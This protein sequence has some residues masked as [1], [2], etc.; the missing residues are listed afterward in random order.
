MKKRLNINVYCFL[1]ALL[2]ATLETLFL[3]FL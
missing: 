3:H 2:V 1:L